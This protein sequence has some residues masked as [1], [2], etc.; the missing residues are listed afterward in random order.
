MTTFGCSWLSNCFRLAI[1]LSNKST[2]LPNLLE[3]EV[4][5]LS[6]KVRSRLSN[7]KISCQTDVELINFYNY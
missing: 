1:D 2:L 4:G 7:E 3:F 5:I 6:E